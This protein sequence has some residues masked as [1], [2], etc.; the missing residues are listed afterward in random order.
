M[1]GIRVA[2]LVL[3]AATVLFAQKPIDGT[4]QMDKSRSQVNDGR[5]LTLAI[6]TF[7]DGTKIKMNIKVKNAA[8][9]ETESEFTTKMNGK[10][11]EYAEGSHKSQM[12]VWYDGPTLNVCKEN[13]PA[14][15]VTSIWKLDVSPDKQT[16]TMKVTH[17]EP[18]SAEETL[19]FVK[20]Q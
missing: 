8:G 18:A 3:A 6:T 13:G 14:D 19:V 7:E 17:Y 4:W 2:T 10:A 11:C 12:T 5:V 9:A 20:K 16:L 15:D 1:V